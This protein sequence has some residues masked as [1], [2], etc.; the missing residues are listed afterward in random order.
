ME[1]M[2]GTTVKPKPQSKIGKHKNTATIKAT[3]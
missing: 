1:D 2:F 3:I